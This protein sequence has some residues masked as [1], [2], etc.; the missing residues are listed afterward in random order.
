MTKKQ[1]VINLFL[2]I[3]I[4]VTVFFQYKLIKQQKS[5]EKVLNIKHA[6]D[7]KLFE[8]NIQHLMDFSKKS[9]KH[10]KRLMRQ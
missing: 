5:F 6:D 2:L 10:G 1:N 8:L 3:A 7:L 4:C 9:S